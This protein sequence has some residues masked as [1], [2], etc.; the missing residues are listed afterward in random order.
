MEPKAYKIVLVCVLLL[1]VQANITGH[2]K[3]LL[4]QTRLEDYVCIKSVH[5]DRPP[6]KSALKIIFLISLPKHNVAGTGYSKEPSQ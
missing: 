4:N 6:D 3:S 1:I 2:K 5:L